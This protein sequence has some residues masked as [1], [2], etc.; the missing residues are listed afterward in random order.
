MGHRERM[1]E[2]SFHKVGDSERRLFVLFVNIHCWRTIVRARGVQRADIHKRSTG[3]G[4]DASRP[5]LRG[6]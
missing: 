1:I 4:E 6:Q 2:R 5:R 3:T